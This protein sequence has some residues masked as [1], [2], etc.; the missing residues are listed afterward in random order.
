MLKPNS[1]WR[2]RIV[3]DGVT[4]CTLKLNGE[5]RRQVKDA[6]IEWKGAEAHGGWQKQVVVVVEVSRMQVMCAGV[7]W[8]VPESN[9]GRR[10]RMVRTESNVGRPR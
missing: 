6:E 8:W 10:I 9:G 3:G 5:G 1:G 4:W 2:R 7:D